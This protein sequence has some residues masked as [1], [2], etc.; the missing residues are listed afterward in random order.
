MGWGGSIVVYCREIILPSKGLL[1][2]FWVALI[3]TDLLF[4]SISGP[5][6]MS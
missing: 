6:M 2:Q 4:F 5:D 3:D 1:G